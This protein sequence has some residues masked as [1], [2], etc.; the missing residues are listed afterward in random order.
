[1][2]SDGIIT[3]LALTA[4]EEGDPFDVYSGPFDPTDGTTTYYDSGLSL[5]DDDGDDDLTDESIYLFLSPDT[6]DLLLGYTPDGTL[7][8]AVYM[9]TVEDEFGNITGG[10]LWTALYEPLFH[11]E[12]GNDDEI[13]FDLTDLIYVA[14][15]E[16]QT[17]NLEG[18]PSG[19][20]LHITATSGDG[21]S[22]VVTGLNPADTSEG[23]T[24]NNWDTVNTS[25]APGY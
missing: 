15:T 6:E 24:L 8:F 7:A 11:P 4:T 9:E 18:A 3:D 12:P 22:I 16:V 5:L 23:Q 17:F 25:K 1:M 19:Q 14:A 10:K 21:V 13:D 20:N 2:S